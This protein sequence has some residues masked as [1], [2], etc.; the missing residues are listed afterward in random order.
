M[1]SEKLSRY[2]QILLGQGMIEQVFID[3]L[4]RGRRVHVERGKKAKKLEIRPSVDGQVP[5]FPV[6]VKVGAVANHGESY[7]PLC[8]ARCLPWM[9]FRDRI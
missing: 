6:V 8:E 1:Q 3:H 2:G 5:D 4:R 9:L 7:Y